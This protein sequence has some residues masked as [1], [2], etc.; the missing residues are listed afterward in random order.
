[1]TI[2]VKNSKFLYNSLK[3]I[4]APAQKKI[5]IIIKLVEFGIY[6]YKKGKQLVFLPPLFC[7]C[8]IRVGK[9]SGSG[10]NTLDPQQTTESKYF[11]NLHNLSSGSDHSRSHMGP[12]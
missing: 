12:S 9:E 10:I 5:I 2:W 8:W 1:V 7:C 4:S 11:K 3:K 6:S